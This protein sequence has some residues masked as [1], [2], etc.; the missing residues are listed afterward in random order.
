MEAVEAVIQDLQVLEDQVEE[1]LVELE[2]H[3][4]LVS[5]QQQE[6]LTLVEV[7]EELANNSQEQPAA[8]ES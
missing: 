5:Q 7:V 3:F 2:L 6:R 1:E 8:L 4:Q